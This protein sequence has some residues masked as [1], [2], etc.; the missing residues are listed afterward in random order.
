LI[1]KAAV[2]A[3]RAV[4]PPP[5]LD[6]HLGFGLA[7]EDLAIEQLV[8][9]GCVVRRGLLHRPH[10]RP[11]HGDD[12]PKKLRFANCSDCP[13]GA[14]GEQARVCMLAMPGNGFDHED[15]H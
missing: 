4:V 8:A 5:S 10:P 11:I 3:D 15:N 9:L 2:R 1:A 7:V 6:Q 14:Y 12:E 13:M